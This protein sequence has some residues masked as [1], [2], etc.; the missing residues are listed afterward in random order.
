MDKVSTFKVQLCLSPKREYIKILQNHLKVQESWYFFSL[1]GVY[2][3][4]SNC[5]LFLS[6]KSLNWVLHSLLIQQKH[7][8]K[9]KTEFLN[10][11]DV[12]LYGN[13]FSTSKLKLNE[14]SWNWKKS[15]HRLYNSLINDCSAKKNNNKPKNKR[16]GWKTNVIITFICFPSASHKTTKSTNIKNVLP[17]SLFFF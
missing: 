1:L 4:R 6:L 12:C 3:F 11:K 2:S 9:I 7:Q 10:T 13:K 16:S 14:E 5:I 17:F 8:N 15:F